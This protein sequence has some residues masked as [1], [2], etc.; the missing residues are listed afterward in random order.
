MSS[1]TDPEA[2]EENQY[3]LPAGLSADEGEEV[4]VQ[5]QYKERAAVLD[6]THLP[7]PAAVQQ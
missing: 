5:Q 2:S 7:S 4:A 3:G 6:H 1:P